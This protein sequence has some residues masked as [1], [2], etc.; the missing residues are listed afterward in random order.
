MVGV[1][2]GEEYT[3]ILEKFYFYEES[4]DRET[5]IETVDY[6]YGDE[7]SISLKDGDEFTYKI[8]NATVYDR[9]KTP[10]GSIGGIAYFNPFAIDV[11]IM[12]PNGTVISDE[13]EIGFGGIFSDTNWTAYKDAFDESDSEFVQEQNN[14]PDITFIYE[15]YDTNN[16]FGFKFGTVFSG[17]NSD[18]DTYSDIREIRYE[19]KT[20]MANLLIRETIR[21]NVEESQTFSYENILKLF[22]KGYS[23]NNDE[24]ALL[25]GFTFYLFSG[26]MIFLSFQ[27][28]K[29]SQ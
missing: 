4:S 11:E 13:M 28:K 3:Y 19:K 18:P 29:N 17:N 5:R 12:G 1:K 26:V 24:T 10:D 16:E 21:T 7:G 20:G 9:S 27:R 6:L 14:N 15:V 22:R 23:Q 8:K 2:N 25:S